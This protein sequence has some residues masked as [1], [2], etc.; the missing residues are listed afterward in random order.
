MDEFDF[1]NAQSVMPALRSEMEA[2]S[3]NCLFILTCNHV[4]RIIPEILSRCTPI[5]FNISDDEKAKIMPRIAMRMMDILKSES[6]TAEPAVVFA[7]VKRYFPDIR[8]VIS[9]LQLNNVG[10]AIDSSILDVVSDTR[11]GT[12]IE[13]L[14]GK[15]FTEMRNWVAAN[16]DIDFNHLIREFYDQA[17]DILE[18]TSIPQL[19]PILDE[20]M[21][22]SA[23][24]VDMEIHTC[25]LLTELMFECQF[26]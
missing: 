14:K 3:S 21:Y 2:V 6:V 23:F 25:A 7:M 1:A 4:N 13:H 5:D 20:Y 26:K 24:V 17:Y 8:R 19:I 22:K 10:G 11:I 9:E 16:N 12:L 15:Q 18:P